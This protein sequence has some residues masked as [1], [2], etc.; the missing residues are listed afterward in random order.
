MGPTTTRLFFPF[1]PFSHHRLSLSAPPA[2]AA[3]ATARPI[4]SRRTRRRPRIGSKVWACPSSLRETFCESVEFS[5]PTDPVMVHELSGD[6]VPGEIRSILS[7]SSEKGQ[8]F[9]VIF[10][11]ICTVDG[12]GGVW[13]DLLIMILLL[14]FMNTA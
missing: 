14:V 2:A 10:L 3:A 4:R 13:Y 7:C 1:L 5:L 11:F 12:V 8:N 9:F 6:T